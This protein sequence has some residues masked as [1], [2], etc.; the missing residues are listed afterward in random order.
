MG[1]GISRLGAA[2]RRMTSSDGN[3]AEKG[4]AVPELLAFRKL[5]LGVDA[6]RHPATGVKDCRAR[7]NMCA[8]YCMSVFV[9]RK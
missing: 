4:N 1:S 7:L 8:Q 9:A 6:I 2:G 5:Q 3:V